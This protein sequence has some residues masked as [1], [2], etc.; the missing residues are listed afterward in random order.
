MSVTSPQTKTAFQKIEEIIASATPQEIEA[1]EYLKNLKKELDGRKLIEQRQTILVQVCALMGDQY[2]GKTTWE[3]FCKTYLFSQGYKKI[4]KRKG[5][6]SK[7]NVK[8]SV[9]SDAQIKDAKKLIEGS[10]LKG[11]YKEVA[12]ELGVNTNSL[13]KALGIARRVTI[14]SS[15]AA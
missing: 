4:S 10:R 14:N 2:K 6:A 3:D 15:V 8:P 13:K 7:R 12:K 5:G 11:N 1:S 9:I